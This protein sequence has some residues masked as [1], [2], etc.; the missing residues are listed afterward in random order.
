MGTRPKHISLHGTPDAQEIESPLAN[1]G[2]WGIGAAKISAC[3]EL[4]RKPRK[5]G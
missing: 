2:K 3:P 1:G 4:R 5:G